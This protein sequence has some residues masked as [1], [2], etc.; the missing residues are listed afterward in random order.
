MTRND[1]IN[2]NNV[3][4]RAS[5]KPNKLYIIQKV[6][7]RAIQKKMYFLFNLSHSRLSKTACGI[8]IA[9]HQRLQKKDGVP[10]FQECYHF[11]KHNFIFP[12]S[13]FSYF[14]ASNLGKI[15]ANFAWALV[16]YFIQ[17]DSTYSCIKECP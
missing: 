17:S 2:K 14:G 5:G 6:L 11:E 1:V 8:R 9:P 16:S 10:G 4:I 3:K 13:P 15:Y 7:I 12:F